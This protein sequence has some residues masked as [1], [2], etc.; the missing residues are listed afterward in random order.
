MSYANDHLYSPTFKIITMQ[1]ELANFRDN[2][3]TDVGH[4]ITWRAN[5]ATLYS[6]EAC[7][8]DQQQ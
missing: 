3:Y 8:G 1:L 4:E 6:D 7:A 2:V 5:W